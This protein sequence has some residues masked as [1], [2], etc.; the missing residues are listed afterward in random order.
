[1]I[2]LRVSSPAYWPSNRVEP[3]AQAALPN[4]APMRRLSP[5]HFH[6]SFPRPAF[7]KMYLYHPGAGRGPFVAEVFESGFLAPAVGAKRRTSKEWV[8]GSRPQ[9]I[10]GLA[11]GQTRGPGLNG[12]NLAT[13]HA[14]LR[15]YSLLSPLTR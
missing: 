7:G 8:N 13:A 15:H 5:S 11:E 3:C 12:E 9:F 10:L 2:P 1:M 14:G 4:A 6:I